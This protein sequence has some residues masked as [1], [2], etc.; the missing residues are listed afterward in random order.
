[1]GLSQESKVVLTFKKQSIR[2][3]NRIK[4]EHP[5]TISVDAERTCDKIHHLFMIKTVRKLG[6]KANS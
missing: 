5:M 1:M 6:I 4:E 3:L 2:Y